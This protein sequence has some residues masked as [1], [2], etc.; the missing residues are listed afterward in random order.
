MSKIIVERTSDYVFQMDPY[1]VEKARRAIMARRDRE[2][3]IMVAA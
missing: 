2:T 1:L 3:R